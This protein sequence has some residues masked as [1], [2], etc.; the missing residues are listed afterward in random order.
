MKLTLSDYYKNTLLHKTRKFFGLDKD[1]EDYRKLRVR[2]H[3]ADDINMDITMAH[4][5]AAC[6]RRHKKTSSGWPYVDIEDL[7]EYLASDQYALP[8]DN[9]NEDR[10]HWVLDEIIWA[11]EHKTT[12]DC[13]FEDIE[14]EK[15]WHNAI[16][17]FGKY[18]N[19]MWI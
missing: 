6:V 12:E 17:L 13:F 16:R 9:I 11:F 14:T 1:V 15:R 5:I 8:E 4:I 10:W 18:Y 2:F 7:P 19:S 3:H